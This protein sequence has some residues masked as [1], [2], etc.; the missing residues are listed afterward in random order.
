LTEFGDALQVA[1]SEREAFGVLRRHLE[2]WLEH[3][4]AVVLVRNA[5]ANRLQAA[6]GL[7]H[8]PVLAQ[9]LE[10]AAPEA[11]LAVRLAKPYLREPG[12]PSLL[13]CDIR[14]GLPA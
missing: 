5:S 6:T 7:E 8:T 1:R 12:K 3:A 13:Q 4:R 11:C 9:K 2:G 14:G 10:A